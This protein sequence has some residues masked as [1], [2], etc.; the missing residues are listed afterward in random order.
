MFVVGKIVEIM[1][2]VLTKYFI[3]C[4]CLPCYQNAI[5]CSKGMPRGQNDCN[6]IVLFTDINFMDS[7]H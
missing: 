3:T 1:T 7:M 5:C 2:L 6:I 4:G